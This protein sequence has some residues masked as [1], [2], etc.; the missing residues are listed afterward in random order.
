[1]TRDIPDGYIAMGVPA[2]AVRKIDE[3]DRMD[4]WQTYVQDAIPMS[5]RDKQK[6]G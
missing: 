5:V 4:V 2:K 6:Q 1:M 3:D